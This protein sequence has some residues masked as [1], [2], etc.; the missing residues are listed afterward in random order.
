MS[1]LYKAIYRLNAM[2]IKIP[3]AFLFFRN[4]TV[5]QFTRN[6]KGL[7]IAKTILKKK[8]NKVVGLTLSDFK[9]C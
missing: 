3:M 4:R 7:Q 6:L 5:L 2:L 8:R 9:I 1:V